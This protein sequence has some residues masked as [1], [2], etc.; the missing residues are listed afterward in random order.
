MKEKYIQESEIDIHTSVQIV[1]KEVVVIARNMRIQEEE[2]EHG[3]N[4]HS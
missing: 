2:S 3:P 1:Q 4:L